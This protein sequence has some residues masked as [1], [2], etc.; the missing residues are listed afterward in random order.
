M[1]IK[2][3]IMQVLWQQERELF[4]FC[5]E[6]KISQEELDGE[7]DSTEEVAYVRGRLIELRIIRR[8]LERIFNEKSSKQNGK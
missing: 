4:K 2:D 7:E 3:K 1:K 8:R 6:E 5:Y